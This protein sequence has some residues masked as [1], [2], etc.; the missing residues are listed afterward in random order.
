MERRHALRDHGRASLSGQVV[1]DELGGYPYRLVRARFVLTDCDRDPSVSSAKQRVADK[2]W[3]TP[4]E[5]FYL[6]KNPFY[7]VEE[8]RS[9]FT[10]I[11]SD[12]TKHIYS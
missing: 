6:I 11:L 4:D 12:Y 3:D 9:P 10:R 1:P 5:G 7:L 8:M 2:P